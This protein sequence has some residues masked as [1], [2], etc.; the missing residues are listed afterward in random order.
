MTLQAAELSLTEQEA[1]FRGQG[2]AFAAGWQ[3]AALG[4]AICTCVNV[5]GYFGVAHPAG[6]RMHTPVTA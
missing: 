4:V 1:A 5:W 6:G 2:T 3:A